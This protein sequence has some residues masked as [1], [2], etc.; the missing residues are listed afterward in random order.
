[1][2]VNTALQK[3]KWLLVCLALVLV[4]GFILHQYNVHWEPTPPDETNSFEYLIHQ[5]E[6]EDSFFAKNWRRVWPHLPGVVQTTLKTMR[7]TLPARLQQ[8]RACKRLRFHGQEAIP[9]LLPKLND[10]DVEMVEAAMISLM[11]INIPTEESWD[12]ITNIIEDETLSDSFRHVVFNVLISMHHK[13][14]RC[15]NFINNLAPKIVGWIN[16]PDEAL[17]LQGKRSKTHWKEVESAFLT[18]TRSRLSQEFLNHLATHDSTFH[19][20]LAHY[21]V[22][23]DI[24]HSNFQHR[25][26]IKHLFT[27][28]AAAY[29]DYFARLTT[30]QFG[31]YFSLGTKDE[32]HFLKASQNESPFMQELAIKFYPYDQPTN[33]EMIEGLIRIISGASDEAADQAFFLFCKIGKKP[34]GGQYQKIMAYLDKEDPVYQQLA[35]R[36][37]LARSSDSFSKKLDAILSCS[38]PHQLEIDSFDLFRFSKQIQGSKEA[39]Q[40][41]VERLEMIHQRVKGIIQNA[42]SYQVASAMYEPIPTFMRSNLDQACRK[43]SWLFTLLKESF[44]ES[45]GL[46]QVLDESIQDSINPNQFHDA[47]LRWEIEPNEKLLQPVLEAAFRPGENPSEKAIQLAVKMGDAAFP[48]LKSFLQHQDE[49]VRVNIFFKICQAAERGNAIKLYLDLAKDGA[50]EE[51]IQRLDMYSEMYMHQ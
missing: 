28:R 48:L 19:N 4:F 30:G 25:E 10:P 32:S 49:F 38:F 12:Y 35:I 20:Q 16:S 44:Q 40:I 43:R 6:K 22:C 21:Y 51:T 7:P 14:E 3:R 8:I 31:Q 17:E 18:R 36:A 27:P 33:V 39:H 46:L 45:S 9:L 23:K 29:S 5:I 11:E 1:M 47:Y 50:S 15:S 26:A 34:T 13:E 41:V 42:S 24:A 2:D 37:I